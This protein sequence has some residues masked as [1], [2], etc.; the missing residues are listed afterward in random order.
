MAMKKLING[1]SKEKM[2]IFIR[3]KLRII[4]WERVSQ[5]V[6]RT[7]TKKVKGEVSIYAI[8][9]KAYMQSQEKIE[10]ATRNR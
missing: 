4:T 10:A 6:L 8:F 7:G 3:T 1:R 9:T 2:G 5:R